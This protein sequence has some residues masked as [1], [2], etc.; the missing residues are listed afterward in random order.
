MGVIQTTYKSW[1]DPLSSKGEVCGHFK[2]ASRFVSINLYMLY[3]YVARSMMNV[4]K[5]MSN[6]KSTDM[7]P[8]LFETSFKMCIQ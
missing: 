4:P 5:K 8:F 7:T 3:I 6:I 1:D 2:V